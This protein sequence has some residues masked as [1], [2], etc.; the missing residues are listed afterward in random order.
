MS[1]S[2]GNSGEVMPA[3]SR[4]SNSDICRAPPSRNALIAGARRAVIQSSPAA[5]ISSLIRAW[6][7]VPR[8]PTRTTWSR[9]KRSFSFVTWPVGS[10]DLRCCRRRLRWPP[11]SR[12]ERRA[13]HRRF[14]ACSVCRHGVAELGERAARR[15]VVEHQRTAAEMAFGEGRLDRWLADC[16]PVASFFPHDQGIG[17]AA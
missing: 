5:L 3:M 1:R 12:Q 4:S 11:D 15:D 9:P 14:A 16:Q 2:P 17:I 10:S 8:S 13:G 7:I 6:V